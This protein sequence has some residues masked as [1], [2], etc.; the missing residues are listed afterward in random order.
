MLVVVDELRL[1]HD[2]MSEVQNKNTL[3]EEQV[4]QLTNEIDEIKTTNAILE[5]NKD[6]EVSTIQR[7]FQEEIASMQH[8]MKGK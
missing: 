6:D 2:S 5:F 3:L 1:V 7:K 4:R 8:I